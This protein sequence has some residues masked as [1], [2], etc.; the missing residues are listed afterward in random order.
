MPSLVRYRFRPSRMNSSLP[1]SIH[2]LIV[3]GETSSARASVREGIRPARGL[4]SAVSQVSLPI[5]GPV[6][7]P[8]FFRAWVLVG[9]VVLGMFGLHRL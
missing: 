8:V 2:L 1:K 3:L 9:L 6:F 5:S 7:S 4:T